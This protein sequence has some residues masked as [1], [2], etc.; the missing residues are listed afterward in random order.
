[1]NQPIRVSVR[2][3]GVVQG[4]G[5]RPFVHAL[6]TRLGLAGHVGNDVDGVFAEVEG[7]RAATADFLTALRA[8]SPPLAVVERVRAKEIAPLGGNGF[9]IVASPVGGSA[10]TLISADSATCADCLRE[11]ADPADR[12]YRYPFVNCTNCGPRFTIV[13]GVPYDRPRTTMSRFA[14]CPD[15]AREYADPAD[16]RFHAQPVCCPVC[17]PRLKLVAGDA[18]VP[19]PLSSTVDM[20]RAGKV[21]AVKGLGGFHLAVDAGHAEAAGVLRARKHREDKP[22]AVMVPD[23]AAARELC[24]VD[25]LAAELLTGRRRPIVLLPRLPDAPVTEAVAPGNRRLGVMLPYTPL[26]HLLLG[27]LGSPIVLTSGNVSDEPIVYRDEEVSPRLDGIA[28]AV[29]TH[30]RAIHIRTDDSVVRPFRGVPQLQRRS[31]GYVPEPVVVPG[32]FPRHVLACGAELKN[33]FCLAK[34]RH[35]FLSHHIGDLENFETLRSFTDGIAHFRRLFDI[36]P[37][38]VAHDLHPEYLSTKY[39]RE[40]DDVELVGVQHHHAHIAS[41]LAD[42]EETGPVLGVAFDGTGFGTDE[43]IWGGEFLAADLVGFRRLGHLAPVPMPGGAAAIKQPWRMA[44][45]YLPEADG[46]DVFRRNESGWDTVVSMAR[47]RVNA[48]LTS[49]AGRLF[50]AVAA[51]LGVRDTINYEGQ[52][53]IELEQLA[54]PLERN[55]Y[56]VDITGGESVVVSGVDLVEACVADLRA[57]VPVPTVAAR[58]HNGVAEM[59]VRVC[60]MLRDATGLGTVALSGGVFQNL[61]LLERSVDSLRDKGF[62]VLT[63]SRVPTNDGGVSLGQAVIAAA[64]SV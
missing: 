17:G 50:D 57:G 61:L 40:L 24:E 32:E 6:A 39:A 51:V 5:F 29:L 26:H 44:A 43:T 59:I 58:F 9:A 1:V 22:F 52:A 60:L 19:D 18:E 30:D 33:T 3:E 63:H 7:D 54:D 62:R 37:R 55:T 15:C 14:M 41:C 16:R 25:D 20:L 8:E 2:V 35:A 53:A 13:R 48:P 4:V 23:L 12:R 28:D 31:R 42:N 21:L 64:Q 38:L 10:A 34:G 46:L 49:S 45:A 27:D 36:E 11:L 56:R 47:R